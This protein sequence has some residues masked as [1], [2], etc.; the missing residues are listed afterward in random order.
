M[1]ETSAFLYDFDLPMELIAQYP[2]KN[3]DSCN[4]LILDCLNNKII[5][6]KFYRL[7]KYLQPGDCLVLNETKVIPARILARK[8]TGGKVEILFLSFCPTS[9]RVLLKPGLKPG[10]KIIFPDGSF[11]KVIADNNNGEFVLDYDRPIAP[12]LENYGLMPLPPYIRRPPDEQDKIF[13]QTVYARKNGSIASPTAGI[14]FTKKVLADLSKKGVELVKI[15]L[16]VGPGTFR[17]V[18]TSDITKHQMLPEYYEISE[19]SARIINQT[20]KN[21]HRLIAVGTTV[22]RALESSAGQDGQVKAT[23]GFAD[24]FIYPGYRFKI[25]K[26]ILTNFHLPRSTPLLLVCA[27]AGRKRI[28]KAYEFAIKEKWRFF[29]YGDAMLILTDSL[30]MEN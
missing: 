19:R 29:S 28:L 20:L 1:K 12:L 11:A 15:L 8:V 27:L 2:R 26:N 23:S 21:H 25:V 5:P 13:Y 4:L 14:H 9:Y 30:R 7:E 24:I 10:Q 18:K 17:P 6:E 22:V 16:H 3:R